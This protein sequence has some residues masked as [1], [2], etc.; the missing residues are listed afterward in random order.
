[1][2]TYAAV[3]QKLKK[4]G[5]QHIPVVVVVL[6]A[7]VAAHHQTADALVRQQGLIDREVGQVRFDSGTFLGIQRLAG[8]KRIQSSR[9]IMRVVG[10]RVRGRP[11]GRWSRTPSHYASGTGSAPG[12]PPAS[13]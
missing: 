1:M 10:E 7:V 13:R 5:A 3:G 12:K 6:V 4:V 9:G 2:R 11:G 8:L